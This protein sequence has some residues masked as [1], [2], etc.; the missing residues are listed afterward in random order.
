[1]SQLTTES[2]YQST[3]NGS[4]GL[5]LIQMLRML[6][7]YGAVLF[8]ASGRLNWLEG[9]VYL[10]M[11]AVTQCISTVVLIP[12]NPGLLAERSRLHP[13]SGTKSW[14][15]YLSLAV[16]LL[17]PLAILVTAGLDARFGW[18]APTNRT[19]WVAAVALAFACQIFVVWAMASNPFFAVTVRIQDDRGTGLSP[20][21]HTGWSGIPATSARC[22]IACCARLCCAHGGPSCLP[23]SLAS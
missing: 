18:T 17:A 23:S 7:A 10:V 2:R 6:I 8:L 3:S 21:A 13:G 19:A 16:A 11:N 4:T 1:M 22:C 20:A 9:W 14:D 15:R 12:R 5:W